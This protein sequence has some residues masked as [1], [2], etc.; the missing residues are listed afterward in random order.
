MFSV[1][2]MESTKK[3]QAM[4]SAVSIMLLNGLHGAT[5][6]ASCSEEDTKSDV[7]YTT[8][9]LHHTVHHTTLHSLTVDA[10]HL[11]VLRK[12]REQFK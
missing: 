6:M 3:L 9:L 5:S 10:C 12:R 8:D 1:I 11:N 4:I 7:G 2:T